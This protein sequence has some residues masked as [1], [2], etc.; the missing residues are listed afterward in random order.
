MV[1]KQKKPIFKRWWFWV[2]VVVIIGAF[3]SIGGD[4]ETPGNIAGNETAGQIEDSNI[5]DKA[6][7]EDSE[8]QAEGIEEQD[9]QAAQ[10]QDEQSAQEEQDETEVPKEDGYINT[11]EEAE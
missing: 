1:Q 5:T 9:G 6:N 11:A 2:I 3:A 8:S 4:K 10:G 7:S